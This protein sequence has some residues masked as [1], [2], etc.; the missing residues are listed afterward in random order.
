M[1][2]ARAMQL[3]LA[4][5][6]ENVLHDWNIILSRWGLLHQDVLLAN[7][8]RVVAWLGIAASLGFLAYH[9]WRG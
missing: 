5:F 9:R 7:G 8:L 4:G 2:D 3:P 6:G 1:A